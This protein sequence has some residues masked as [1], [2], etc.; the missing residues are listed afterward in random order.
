MAWATNSIFNVFDLIVGILLIVAACISFHATF[1]G[2]IIP[3]YIFL[4]GA[5]IIIMVFYVPPTLN[6]M[7][8]FY[9][10]FLGRGLTFLFLGCLVLVG[11]YHDVKTAV[12]VITLVVAFLYVILWILYVFRVTPCSLPPP[13][14]QQTDDPHNSNHSVAGGSN[15]NFDDEAPTNAYDDNDNQ[16][17]VGTR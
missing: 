12:A 2:V 4:F 9:M 14:L 6:A 13:F 8:P 3:V 11:I 1:V 7:I 17:P 15:K 10:N 5:L 16:T